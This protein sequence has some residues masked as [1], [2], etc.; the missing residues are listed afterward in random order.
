MYVHVVKRSGVAAE[1]GRKRVAPA[2][3]ARHGSVER[4]ILLPDWEGERRL[5]R[6]RFGFMVF[7]KEKGNDGFQRQFSALRHQLGGHAADD[8]EA[9]GDAG[10]EQIADGDSEQHDMPPESAY[11]E[12]ASDP[13]GSGDSPYSAPASQPP[14]VPETP[15][16]P[17]F[18]LAEMPSGNDASVIAHDAVWDGN[19]QTNGSLHVHG[20]VTGTLQAS[21]S[22][23][24]AEEANVDGTVTAQNVVVGGLVKGVVHCTARFE[25]LATGRVIADIHAPTVVVH[26]GATMRGGFQMDKV[27][28]SD[29]KPSQ[30][31]R[32][33]SRH[34]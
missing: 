24:I 34:R 6:G 30:P 23:Y 2:R 14:A 13:Y 4:R 31:Y 1:R 32:R 20:T 5:L 19:L 22:V 11:R 27:S 8:D 10:T 25:A 16:P 17:A 15:T 33:A 18:D 3:A 9:H 29:E 12:N 7:R 26:E 28:A 21:D